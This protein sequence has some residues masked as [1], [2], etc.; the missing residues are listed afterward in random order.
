M[1]DVTVATI[2]VFTVDRD[3]TS[4]IKVLLFNQGNTTV[5]L[6]KGDCITQLIPE[7]YNSKPLKE[8]NQI[9]TTEWN[10]QG[11]RSMGLNSLEPDLVEIYT[12]DLMPTATD[13]AL[14]SLTPSH[15]HHKLHLFNPEGPL[16]Q[17][18]RDHPDDDFELQLNPTKPLPKPLWPYHM[19]PAECA[20]WIKWRDTMLAAGMISCAPTSTPLAAPFFFV[21]KKDGT[22][23]P[24]IDYRKLNNITIKDS[25]PLPRIDETLEQMH[26]AKIFSKFNL[27]MGYNQLSIKKEDCWKTAFMTPDGPFVINVMTFGFAN[28][29]AYF[30]QWMS[31]VLQPVAGQC[32]ENYLDDTAT[33]HNNMDKCIQ[34]NLAVLDCF[35]WEGIFL[36]ASKCKFHQEQMNFL[37][38]DISAKG[39]EM[40]KLKVE[41]IEEWKPPKNVQG[42]REFIGFCNF[43][44]WFIKSFSKIACPLHDLTKVGQLWTWG[45]KEQYAFETLKQMVC[46][47]PVLIHTNPEKKFQMETNM[48]SYTYGAVLSQKAE[49][50]KH[51]PVAFYSKSMNPTKWNYGISNKEALPIIKG[52]QHW[53]HWLEG[54]R[55]PIWIITDHHNLEYFKNPHPLNRQQLRWWEQLTHYNYEIGY[56]PG[57][58]NSAANALSRKE[59]HR[60]NQT[61]EKNPNVLFDPQQFIEVALLAFID[62][63]VAV[64]EGTEQ[65]YTLTDSQLLENISE[66][67]CHINPLNYNGHPNTS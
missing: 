41:A 17:Q 32:M 35:E 60:P 3:Y 63:Q 42:V 59:E 22:W 58:K 28:T 18:P 47:S 20:D 44:C 9:P 7:K 6:C 64:L 23:Q 56:Q 14:K 55:E 11:F 33:H 5:T 4:R 2:T 62:E 65:A 13:E 29:L 10:I 19:N 27:K 48:S 30:Q 1:R 43:Y 21:W 25:F 61:D 24:V 49:D 38:V 39:F 52:L 54:T 67:M 37:G 57:D 31:K 40:E 36:N 8:V 34:T 51:H 12:I 15:Y 66:H 50:K 26:G 53:R 45:E 46:K 16:K